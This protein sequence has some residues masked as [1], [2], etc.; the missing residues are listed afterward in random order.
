MHAI[1]A[2]V[3][4]V[5]HTLGG[6]S[7][8]A[9]A[10]ALMLHLAKIAAEARSWHAIVSHAYPDRDVRFPTTLGAFAGA[11]GANAV[12]PARVGEALRLGIVRRRV[13]GSSV[14]TIASTIVLETAIELVF[15]LAVIGAVLGAGRSLGP[16]A[17][18]T[19]LVAA[20]PAVLAVVGAV[21]VLI[22]G[23]GFLGRRRLRRAAAG[24]ARGMA[25]VR[26]PRRFFRGVIVWKLVAWGL[27]L[28]AVYWFL[29]AFHLAAGLWAVL[30]VVAAQ[31]LAALLPLA[32]G[33]AGTQQAALAFALAGTA[34]VAA[35]VGLGIGM[36]ASTALIDLAIGTVAVALVSSRSDVRGALRP[37][38]RRPAL[39]PTP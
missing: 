30:L 3:S 31:N 21:S 5:A 8:G 19:T 24:M 39:A 38:R 20:H 9:L 28:A 26:S 27:R 17:A 35:A 6:A 4:G 12:L 36:Q 37:A 34:S 22:A 33:G 14:A 32:P 15:G 29:T 2:F 10:V 18:P 7:L 16:I 11:V 1:P 25:I 23:A 13:P